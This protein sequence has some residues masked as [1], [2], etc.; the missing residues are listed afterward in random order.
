MRK[1]WTLLATSALLAGV[2]PV[3][4]VAQKPTPQQS[5]SREAR[6]KRERREVR[7]DRREDRIEKAV[8]REFHTRPTA[9]LKG[10]ELNADQRRQIE[11][12][13]K[14][15][16]DQVRAIGRDEDAREENG[17]PVGV[18]KDRLVDL[19]HKER[20]EIRSVLNERQRDRFDKNVA[21]LRDPWA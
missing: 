4:A 2:A 21:D 15:T 11:Q 6:I 7:R 17:K 20:D 12:I 9:W 18:F 3:V 19:M 8:W 14:R 5:E 13:R 1:T 16:L 10:I